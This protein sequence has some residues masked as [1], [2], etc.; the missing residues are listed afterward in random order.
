[1]RQ[2]RLTLTQ[3]AFLMVIL[4][5]IIPVLLVGGITFS[6]SSQLLARESSAF[7]ERILIEEEEEIQLKIHQMETLMTALSGSEDIRA[8][9]KNASS[10]TF[11]RLST[12]ANVG[13]VLNSFL[14]IS[15]LVAIN[16]FSLDGHHYHVGDTLTSQTIRPN[17]RDRLYSEAL[18]SDRPVLWTGIEDNV[19]ADST[20]QKVIMGVSLITEIDAQ[21]LLPTPLGFIALSY[22]PAD[23]ASRNSL[24][25]ERRP[26]ATFWLIDEKGRYIYHPDPN[27]LGQR[28]PLDR[29]LKMNNSSGEVEYPLPDDRLISRYRKV[30]PIGWL[31]AY[32]LPYSELVAPSR[33]VAEGTLGVMIVSVGVLAGAAY[34]VSR[35]AVA[36]IRQVTARFQQLQAHPAQLPSPLPVN[37]HDEV[38]DLAQGFNTF[39]ETL[40]QRQQIEREREQLIVDLQIA[41]EKA[42]QSSRLKSE[43]LATMSHELR[44]PLNAIVGYTEILLHGFGVTIEPKAIGM[45]ER[46][47]ANSRRLLALI[48]DLLDL[49]RIESGRFDLSYRRIVPAE[50]LARW[51]KEI[52]ILGETKGLVLETWLDP[53]LP[54]SLI[55]D[56]EALTKIVVNLLSN[57][58]KF[59]VRGTIFLSWGLGKTEE[60]WFIGVHDTGIGVPLHA[61]EFIFE[62]FRQ[63][64]QSSKREHGGTGLG[65]AIVKRLVLAMKGQIALESEIGQGSTF[66]VTFPYIGATDKGSNQRIP[67]RVPVAILKKEDHHD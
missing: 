56:A 40:K 36:P 24:Y 10:S 21:T 54:E 49:S 16:V 8:L 32:N 65:L 64:D 23:L 39:L 35:T 59:T 2:P 13:Y 22:D 51:V 38:G 43:F 50:L 6:L 67:V 20:Y 62:E 15:G 42:E 37:R 25:D 53:K 52:S 33:Q 17:I 5:S 44:T 14:N 41:N 12:E 48:N 26:T 4:L 34:F 7:A 45:L 31:I 3:R 60:D 27:T 61:R 11:S 9:I 46:V 30:E 57:A 1:M 19:V 47:S 58:F 28:V 29:L 18:S 55:S 66:T 63:V